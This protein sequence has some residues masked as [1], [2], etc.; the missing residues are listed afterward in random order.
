MPRFKPAKPSPTPRGQFSRP[1]RR[2]KP[3][4]QPDLIRPATREETVPIA[5]AALLLV[6]CSLLICVSHNYLL[7]YGDAVAHL[8][9]ARR[10]VDTRNPGLQQFGGVWLPLPH[11]VMLPFIRNMAWWQSGLAGAWPSMIFYIIGVIGFYRLCRRI[12]V[13]RWAFAATAFYALNP[14]LLYLATTAMTEPLFLAIV[15]WLTLLTLEAVAAIRAHTIAGRQLIVIALLILAAVYTRYDG[16]ILGAAIWLILTY[17]LARNPELLRKLAPSFAAFTLITIAGPISWFV[18]NHVYA[19]DWL[20]FMRGPY[21]AYQIDLRTKP[22]GDQH[23]RGW[24][25]PFW[26]LLF[27]TRTAQVDST[28]WEFGFLT[29]L[30]GLEGIVLLLRH[31][32]NFAREAAMVTRDTAILGTPGV[33]Y[34]REAL[35]TLL[36]WLPLP[37]YVYSISWGSV[38][39]FIPNLWPHAFYNSRYGME[40]LPAL[41]LFA[42]YA[43][44][45]TEVRLAEKKPL[46]ARLFQPITLALIAINA[47]AMIYSIPLVLREAQHNSTTRIPFEEAIAHEI[48]TFPRSVPILMQESD[49][50]GALQQAGIPLKQTINETDYDS[51]HAA[52]ADP[53]K[54]AA[55]VIA[56]GNDEVAKAVHQHPQ[57]LTELVVLCTT[58]QSCARVY[59]SNV[60]QP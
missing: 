54:H 28:A 46:Y 34:G 26:A 51:F 60:Y 56:M 45:A 37:F 53:A 57:D 39:I 29:M 41:A 16:W 20:D 23:H 40:L 47:V 4:P 21:S 7:L 14:N 3:D 10:I 2:Y 24:H 5:F 55:Y 25:N 42:A 33:P 31:I 11:L 32:R 9:I 38:P 50:V 22:P 44:S 59:K 43:L 36:L 17:H 19:H 49:H 18:Y 15:I 27:Y 58:G 1:T 13:P 6:F 52:L 30:C 35:V 48:E 12:L 8:G